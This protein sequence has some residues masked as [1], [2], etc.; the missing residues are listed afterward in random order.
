MELKNLSIKHKLTAI[1]MLTSSVVLV[2][3]C[4]AFI[5]NDAINFRKAMV[6]DTSTLAEVIGINST[7]ALSFNDQKAAEETLSAL[8]AEPHVTAAYIYGRDGKVFAGYPDKGFPSP[9]DM[10]S[11][12]GHRFLKDRMELFKP[13]VLDDDTIGTVYIETDLKEFYSR[14]LWY[15][16][17][18]TAILL[19]F[20]LVAY[21]LSLKLQ[22]VISEPILGLSRTMKTVS[23]EK[24]YSVRAEKKS[25][26]ELGTLIEG[27]NVMLAQIQ[28]RDEKLERHR[29]LLE[30]KVNTRTAELSK[31][32]QE[33]KQTVS[34]LKEAKEAAEAATRAKSQFLANMSHEIR[35]PMNGVLGMIGMLLD[36]DLSGKQRRFA[37]TVRHSGEVLLNIISEILD[38][39]KIEAGKLKLE[40]IPFDLRKNVEEA[41][42]LF[43]D[44]AHKKGIELI[45][46]I[47][48][49]VPAAPVGDP[50]RL[51]QVLINLISNAVKFT[52]RGEITVEVKEVAPDPGLNPEGKRLIAFSVTD[53]GIGI[54]QGPLVRL[55]QPFTQA[56]GS[57]TRKYGGTGLGLTI[58]KQLVE[59]MG[60]EIVVQSEP[61]KGSA[62]KFTLSLER[63]D[64][65]EKPQPH[66][67]K[68]L[69]V[70][71]VD[72]NSTSRKVIH[73]QILSWGMRNGCAENGLEALEILKR[74][75][76]LGKPYQIAILDMNTPG[77][78]GIELA[79]TIKADPLIAPVR[80]V[81]MTSNEVTLDAEDVKMCGVV[82]FLSKPVRQSQLYN[83]LAEAIE[84]KIRAYRP[85]AA[86]GKWPKKKTF[87][88][89]VLL[90]E[91]SPVNQEVGQGMLEGLGCRVDLASNGLD[92]L[93]A[94]SKNRYDLIFMDIQ[95]PEMD[96][97]ETTRAVRKKEE[98]LDGGKTPIIA[99]TANALD[100]DRER[101]ISS[102]MDDYLSK[103]FNQDQ[104][105]TVLERWLPHKLA[106]PEGEADKHPG[107]EA[108]GEGGKSEGP[109]IDRKMLENIRAL[110]REGERDILHRII[111]KYLCNSPE[112][113][114]SLR[115]A[116][117]RGDASAIQRVAHSFKSSSANLGALSLAEM[118]RNLEAM[119]RMNSLEEAPGLIREVEAE[120]GMVEE[121]LKKEFERRAS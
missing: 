56:D 121:S 102:G 118:L 58:T 69:R 68:D 67:L 79:K 93:D 38:F 96:G 3:A 112:L 90:A 30:E 17:I 27:F 81:L 5:A 37:E 36:T 65:N 94:H 7:A 78:N 2:L 80:I 6:E 13:I 32:N 99:L 41:V 24:N 26:D 98:S 54:P 87:H 64:K 74:E 109:V 114:R 42:E 66:N 47:H 15:A 31:A 52:E 105:C 9:F 29:E 115:E 43:A 110:Q 50:Y 14:L 20:S 35:T 120:Y 103:P 108:H 76:S 71:V 101:C 25:N 45:C 53:T 18:S 33:L 83:C 12:D 11:R 4:L 39:S 40:K 73:H 72:G 111:E 23:E 22:R 113:I 89:T 84:E 49:D 34:E 92:V 75:A 10:P 61:G 21:I 8:R 107:T 88:A 59:M 104:L 60:G 119:G 16:G 51:Q 1:I 62:F 100:G 55:F 106:G 70:L 97:H 82:G 95:M 91:D 117:K 63:S 86:E 28:E 85:Y 77:M 44:K 46:F 48:E 116:A 19:G 57:T